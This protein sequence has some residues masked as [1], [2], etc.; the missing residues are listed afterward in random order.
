MILIL[1]QTDSNSNSIL[2]EKYCIENQVDHQ[3]LNVDE[4]GQTVPFTFDPTCSG[5]KLGNVTGYTGV[6]NAVFDWVGRNIIGKVS[7]KYKQFIGN[8]LYGSLI[9]SLIVLPQINWMNHPQSVFL[10]GFK[11]HQ[12]QLARDVGFTVPATIVS[13]DP[14]DL[15]VF[16]EEHKEKGVIIKS[17]FIGHV[18][19]SDGKHELLFT[20]KVTQ[21]HIDKLPDYC[22]PP[23]LFQEMVQKKRELRI[24][25]VDSTVFCCTVGSDT[26]VVDWRTEDR[27]TQFSQVVELPTSIEAK[28]VA[29]VDRLQLRMG[30]LDVIEDVN[31][32]Y[33][34][35]EVNQ[36]GGWG[37]L[38][39]KL[40]LP[41]SETIVTSLRK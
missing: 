11:L 12:L 29:L 21:T 10:A 20:N 6:Y 13:S 5:V 8:E 25:V 4:F 23:V 17:V 2:V 19:T 15:K 26:S 18:A 32:E 14:N 1:G 24:V 28:C 41:I 40:G 22:S 30:V 7:P 16:W 31:G 9:G 27:P 35:L 39:T 37:W 33:N 34:F 36:Q 3:M 38:E